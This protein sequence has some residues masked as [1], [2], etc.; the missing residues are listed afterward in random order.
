[1]GAKP[2]QSSIYDFRDYRKYLETRLSTSGETR[3]F[4]SKLALRLNTKPA[5]ISQVLS[6]KNDF[7]LEHCPV[8]NESLGHNAEESHYFILLV[9]FARAGS[10]LLEDFFKVQIDDV[11]EK[12]KNYL[13]RIKTSEV[14]SKNQEGVYYSKWYYAAI[15]LLTSI[16]EFQTKAAIAQRINLSPT[17]ISEAIEKLVELGLLNEKNGRFRMTNK[18]ILLKKDS[19]WIQQMHTHYRLR[20][21]QSFNDPKKDDFHYSLGVSL[22]KKDYE[23]IRERVLQMLEELDPKMRES[24]EEEAYYL[25][26]DLFQMV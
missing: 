14:L 24:K 13:E 4:R 23:E 25:I 11:L 3:G 1:M 12:R 26:I 15:H 16:P 6:G 22:S 5:F 17:L 9:L 8:I 21:I 20:S 18:R 2:L 10:K 7:T 19:P